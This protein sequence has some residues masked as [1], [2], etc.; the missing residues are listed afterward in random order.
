MKF[1]INDKVVD[2]LPY[3]E[4]SIS[5]NEEIL[6]LNINFCFTNLKFNEVDLKDFETNLKNEFKNF[7]KESETEKFV[8][9]FQG[10]KKLTEAQVLV[11]F[12][13]LENIFV[14]FAFGKIKTK[15]LPFEWK[16]S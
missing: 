12:D 11:N 13:N 15:S 1:E 5:F 3:V 6:G 9:S 16:R 14:S 4:N 8:R 7:L 2:H 10:V